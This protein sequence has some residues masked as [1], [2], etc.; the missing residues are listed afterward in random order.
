MPVPR[1]CLHAQPEIGWNRL[2]LH[3][4]I[5]W[6]QRG[7][8]AQND[9][10]P[11][12][13]TGCDCKLARARLP[14]HHWQLP[15]SLSP[16]QKDL[17]VVGSPSRSSQ[18]AKGARSSGKFS[19]VPSPS[20]P[21]ELKNGQRL[22]GADAAGHFAALRSAPKAIKQQDRRRSQGKRSSARS[23]PSKRSP[24]ASGRKAVASLRSEEYCFKAWGADKSGIWND[25]RATW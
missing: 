14:L 2:S 3:R 22:A 4:Q 12:L 18:F 10:K 15:F 11:S 1:T 7:H 21:T 23:W 5:R 9:S 20:R 19:R 24:I 6:S 17:I 25:C 8:V 16:R 13:P